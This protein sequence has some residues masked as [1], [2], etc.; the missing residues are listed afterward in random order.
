MLLVNFTNGEAKLKNENEKMAY[1]LISIN[2]CLCVNLV[3]PS[4]KVWQAHHEE[5]KTADLKDYNTDKQSI[6][7]IFFAPN[8]CV[9][10]KAITAVGEN[11]W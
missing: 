9:A 2:T 3:V 6:I 4:E 8:S 5:A 10:G 7:S 11:W 1:K